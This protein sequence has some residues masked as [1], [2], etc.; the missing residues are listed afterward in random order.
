MKDHD[1]VY[2]LSEQCTHARPI[3]KAV[4]DCVSRS[5]SVFPFQASLRR[6]VRQVVRVAG[7]RRSNGCARWTRNAQSTYSKRIRSVANTLRSLFRRSGINMGKCQG[8][9]SQH[10]STAPLFV[11]LNAPFVT[12]APS[13]TIHYLY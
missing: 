2:L 4:S 11:G 12:S 1:F 9:I 8:R 3:S 5:I 7:I 10:S 6:H 13:L